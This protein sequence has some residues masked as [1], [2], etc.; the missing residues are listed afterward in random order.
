MK[1]KLI[2]PE[3]MKKALIESAIIVQNDAKLSC[4]VNTGRLR[5]SISYALDDMPGKIE[6][7]AKGQDAVTQPTQPMKA[8]I[9]T[10]VEYGIFVEYMKSGQFAFLRRALLQNIKNIENKFKKALKESV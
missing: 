6:G 7:N 1:A 3:L 5:G 2:K 4:P 8:N 9:G 10:N